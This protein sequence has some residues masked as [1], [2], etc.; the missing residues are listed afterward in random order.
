MGVPGGQTSRRAPW[1]STYRQE[2]V[3]TDSVSKWTCPHCETFQ[4]EHDLG[5]QTFTFIRLVDPLR[6]M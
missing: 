5:E 3:F 4:Q 2:G 6:T 1:I